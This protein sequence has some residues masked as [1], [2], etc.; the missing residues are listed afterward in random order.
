MRRNDRE[1]SDINTIKEILDMNK[2]ANLAMVDDGMPYLV[3]MNYGYEVVDAQLVLYFHCA[4]EG[5]KLQIL[6]QNNAVCFSIFCEGEPLYAETPCNSG[7][8]YSSVIGNGKAEF[9]ETSP[10]KEHALHI[11]VAQQTGKS[12]TF[13]KEQAATVCVFKVISMDFTGKRKQ[14]VTR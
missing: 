5:R 7:Y 10:E 9:I 12:Y 2:T 6:K 4:T 3:P 14:K 1:V 11:I 13:T 8:F